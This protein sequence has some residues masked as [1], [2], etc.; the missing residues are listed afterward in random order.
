MDDDACGSTSARGTAANGFGG[1]HGGGAMAQVEGDHAG[2]DRSVETRDQRESEVAGSQ[3]QWACRACTFLN[4]RGASSCAMCSTSVPAEERQPD[5]TYRD[6]LINDIAATTGTADS[7]GQGS[8]VY[9]LTVASLMEAAR[10]RTLERSRYAARYTTSGG[11]VGGGAGGSTVSDAATGSAVGAIG[12]GLVSAMTPGN[13]P[14]HVIAS[15]LQGALVGG[16]AG[17][18]MGPEFR[19]SSADVRASREPGGHQMDMDELD[20]E[21]LDPSADYPRQPGQVPRPPQP[22]PAGNRS[23][24]SGARA[25]AFRG[26]H[27]EVDLEVFMLAEYLRSIGMDRRADEIMH[28]VGMTEDEMMNAFWSSADRRRASR[29]SRRHI[30]GGMVEERPADNRRNSRPATAGTVAS[31]PEEVLTS[32]SVDRM[33][34][35]ERHCC[36]CLENFG[37]GEVATRLP[38]LHLYHTVCIQNWLATSGTCPQCKHRVD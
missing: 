17:A 3:S 18:A 13:R 12:A 32:G 4:E 10:E 30:L 38:C 11:G 7:H 6:T 27:T 20:F 26:E 33:P 22:P 23:A 31:L 14:G 8:I 28:G 9:P 34:A 36:I 25:N 35:D 2:G 1:G 19:R 5:A 21:D 15:M 29:M 16:V 24:S 37:D